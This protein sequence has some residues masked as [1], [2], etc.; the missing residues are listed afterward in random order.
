MLL[1][2]INEP[3][4]VA[5]RLDLISQ[6][7]SESR[8]QIEYQRAR[9]LLLHAAQLSCTTLL[10]DAQSLAPIESRTTLPQALHGRAGHARLAPDRLSLDLAD[11]IDTAVS[12]LA[13][14]LPTSPSRRQS[15]GSE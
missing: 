4:T 14:L 10:P 13:R 9:K 3:E 1:C 5:D 2:S 11:R 8:A 7:D 15:D 12:A 6:R